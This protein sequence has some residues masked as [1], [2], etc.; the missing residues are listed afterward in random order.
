[1]QEIDE[2]KIHGILTAIRDGRSIN[3]FSQHDI[4]L[5]MLHYVI[6]C[7]INNTHLTHIIKIHVRDDIDVSY[8]T[9]LMVKC[10]GLIDYDYECVTGIFGEHYELENNI[11]SIDNKGIGMNDLIS[12]D[13]GQ[14]IMEFSQ[15]I[16]YRSDH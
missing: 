1:M 6:W 12:V 15:V 11:V 8:A 14:R 2:D 13:F 9:V 10:L 16:T 4:L 7:G 3:V 5:A